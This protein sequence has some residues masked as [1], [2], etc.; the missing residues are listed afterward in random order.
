MKKLFFL[1][2]F[3]GIGAVQIAAQFDRTGNITE[4]RLAVFQKEIAPIYRK[5]S[6]KELKLVEPRRELF[7]KYAAFLRQP[8]TGLTKLIADKGCSENMKV[9]VSNGKVVEYRVNMRITFVLKD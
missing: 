6:K 5:P 2:L 1:I 9:V 7:D 4:R 3:V 8:N